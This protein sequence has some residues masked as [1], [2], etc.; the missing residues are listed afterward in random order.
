MQWPNRL[1]ENSTFEILLWKTALFR[2][3]STS[4]RPLEMA[5]SWSH[6]SFQVV[7]SIFQYQTHR[8]IFWKSWEF[9]KNWKLENFK[10]SNLGIF[11]W[12][13]FWEFL[14]LL[15]NTTVSLILECWFYYLRRYVGSRNGHFK[16]SDPARLFPEKY[17]YT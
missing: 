3:K 17:S 14:G 4:T 6:I 2:C 8:G 9:S 1:A 13:V 16:R 5:I 10:G 7:K 15:K 12:S 11:D